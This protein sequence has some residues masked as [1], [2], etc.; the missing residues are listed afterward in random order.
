LN[1][2][3]VKVAR[4]DKKPG[5]G[6]YW[7]L[8]PE[9][10]SMFDNGS[11]LR[12]KRRFKTDMNSL[13]RYSNS[14]KRA[15]MERNTN[16]S[17]SMN[18]TTEK[19]EDTRTDDGQHPSDT[20]AAHAEAESNSTSQTYLLKRERTDLS[21]AVPYETDE[22]CAK[23]SAHYE[24]LSTREL[25]ATSVN[26]HPLRS[27]QNQVEQPVFN[28]TPDWSNSRYPTDPIRDF[29]PPDLLPNTM[30]VTMETAFKSKHDPRTMTDTNRHPG[31]MM[32]MC[33]LNSQHS[34]HH[35]TTIR[36]TSNREDPR[37]FRM[38]DDSRMELDATQPEQLSAT[39]IQTNKE[40]NLIPAV[41]DYSQ[42]SNI[43]P[44]QKDYITVSPTDTY[45][46]TKSPNRKSDGPP[47]YMDC[48]NIPLTAEAEL[49]SHQ[50]GTQMFNHT[51]GYTLGY[52]ENSS[53][54]S[55]KFFAPLD[56]MKMAAAAAIAW[57]AHLT[58]YPSHDSF[59]FWSQ[60]N[61]SSESCHPSAPSP[62]STLSPT[63]TVTEQMQLFFPLDSV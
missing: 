8:H 39:D 19:E 25:Y 53:K 28:L 30:P 55:S 5:K 26:Y 23:Y 62:T 18:G 37:R 44:E 6:S 17:V 59:A 21:S 11:F 41:E 56:T 49:E 33:G 20:I 13:G 1:D 51:P 43:K 40:R 52:S 47:K 15:L 48:A 22:P 2:C 45:V 58:D 60:T 7:T 34:R 35:E 4:D 14:K 27:L 3:F 12:R 46:Y 32:M 24:P 31:V 29:R 50:T 16:K 9:A 57:Q 54:H 38:T 61:Q 36:D 63:T 42:G 10:H